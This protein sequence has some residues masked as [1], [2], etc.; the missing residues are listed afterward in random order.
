MQW[1][2][3]YSGVTM[4]GPGIVLDG[5]M[6]RS[7]AEEATH[8][9]ARTIMIQAAQRLRREAEAEFRD[10]LVAELCNITSATK[11]KLDAVRRE[12]SQQPGKVD[13]S[14]KVGK[15]A[16]DDDIYVSELHRA[17]EGILKEY[18]VLDDEKLD[19]INPNN[20]D[21]FTVQRSPTHSPSLPQSSIDSSSSSEKERVQTNA[22]SH[23]GSEE[24]LGKPNQIPFRTR[25]LAASPPPKTTPVPIKSEPDPDSSENKDWILDNDEEN[26]DGLPLHR[27]RARFPMTQDAPRNSLYRWFSQTPRPLSSPIPV[28]A[29]ARERSKSPVRASHHVFGLANV[30]IH[31][32]RSLIRP[33][34]S[35][36]DYP[37]RGSKMTGSNITGTETRNEI[38][39]SN[40]TAPPRTP[41]RK[42]PARK[43]AS[44]PFTYNIRT[45]FKNQAGSLYSPEHRLV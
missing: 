10:K 38:A 9:R 36:P 37:I 40:E 13:A 8:N 17:A 28:P 23:H 2:H 27:R 41:T 31:R 45:I 5:V 24:D 21:S 32:R 35:Q 33:T 15:N 12:F 43:S 22:A 42:Q 6:I 25:S 20:H 34:A 7:A 14:G 18:H 39:N 4:S 11:R 3:G 44:S 1:R 16:V 30:K 19:N 26:E 29:H